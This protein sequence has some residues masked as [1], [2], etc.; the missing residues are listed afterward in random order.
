MNQQDLLQ[1]GYK[2]FHDHFKKANGAYQKRVGYTRYFINVYHYD[3]RD[4]HP[5]FDRPDSFECDLQFQLQDEEHLNLLFNCT[6]L[7]IEEL[8]KKVEHL[9]TVLNALPY[10]E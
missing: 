8:E 6:K 9:F 1:A 3:W 10:E 2:L 5:S 4:I 7:S